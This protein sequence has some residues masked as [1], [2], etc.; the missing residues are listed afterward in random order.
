MTDAEPS[1][2]SRSSPVC[3]RGRN[4]WFILASRTDRVVILRGYSPE[5][6]WLPRLT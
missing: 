2:D 1:H 3:E 6:D 5:A 4:G